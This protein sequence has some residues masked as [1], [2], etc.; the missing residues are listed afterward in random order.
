MIALVLAGLTNMWAPRQVDPWVQVWTELETLRSGKTSP[1]EADVLRRHLGDA[2][3]RAADGPRADLLDA[4]LEAFS[5]RD[6]TAAAARLCELEPSPFT[7]RE[8][9]LLADLAPHGPERARIILTALDAALPLADWQVLLAWNVAV[10]E[11]RA[12]RLEDTALPIQ[13]RLHER[14]RAQWSAEDLALTYRFLGREQA[15]A[16]ILEEAIRQERTAG[17][18]PASLLER[19]G[20][21]ALGFGDEAEARDYLGQALAEGSD[22]SGLL[23]ARLDLLSGKTENARC[24]FQA[25]LHKQPPA[26]WAWRGWGAAL[27]PEPFVPPATMTLLPSSE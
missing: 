25:L 1:T 13:T 3:G 22:D 14:Y 4:G 12:L 7:T 19:R 2:L 24:G 10:D 8:L 15:A 18:R 20:I 27:L 21:H 9:W 6:V 16:Q 5:G 23:I 17:R 11:A 26:D